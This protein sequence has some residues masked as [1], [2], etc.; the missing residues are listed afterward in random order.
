VCKSMPNPQW[1]RVFASATAPP[2]DDGRVFAWIDAANR[3]HIDC[4]LIASTAT[5]TYVV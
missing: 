2:L 1:E 4:S 5:P 3:L